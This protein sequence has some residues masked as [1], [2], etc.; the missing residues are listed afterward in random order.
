MYPHVLR[1][2]KIIG[3]TQ[4]GNA[5]E[6]SFHKSADVAPAGTGAV[7]FH[8]VGDPFAREIMR[9]GLSIPVAMAT[10]SEPAVMIF[11]QLER[12]VSR[13]FLS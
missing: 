7:A 11:R 9:I 10:K 6:L 13:A 5:D 8:T 12:F 3:M 4:D 2:P 1:C